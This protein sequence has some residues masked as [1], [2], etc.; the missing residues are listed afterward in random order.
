M[1]ELMNVI[2]NDKTSSAKRRRCT[3]SRNLQNCFRTPDLMVDQLWL[4][5]FRDFAL[6]NLQSE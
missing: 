1:I 3:A 4:G 5:R 2:A 6:A